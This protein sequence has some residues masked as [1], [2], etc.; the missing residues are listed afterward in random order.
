MLG[1]NEHMPIQER[2]FEQDVWTRVEERLLL[3]YE[4]SLFASVVCN[5]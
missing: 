5:I 2:I 4:I 1:H 3:W